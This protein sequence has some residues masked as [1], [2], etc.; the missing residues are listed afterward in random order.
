LMSCFKDFSDSFCRLLVQMIVDRRVTICCHPPP[1][2]LSVSPDHKSGGRPGG[3][4]DALSSFATA[5]LFGD[6]GDLLNLTLA[7]ACDKACDSR[8][9]A[10]YLPRISGEM[11]CL[12]GS[13][14]LVMLDIGRELGI[15]CLGIAPQRGSNPRRLPRLVRLHLA[16]SPRPHPVESIACLHQ[17][18][19]R[20]E[21]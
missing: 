14:R 4:S 6:A 18:T 17:E 21:P 5:Q 13:S 19:L 20:P 7:R 2:T 15:P 8:N 1:S 3:V 12:L 16:V 10:S 9:S 11:G